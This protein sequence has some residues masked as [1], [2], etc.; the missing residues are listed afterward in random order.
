MS[1]NS[2]K[3]WEKTEDIPRRFDEL[4]PEP[5]WVPVADV[6]RTSREEEA[7]QEAEREKFK[8]KP[9]ADFYF[10]PSEGNAKQGSR[11]RE[12]RTPAHKEKER[13][14]HVPS[15]RADDTSVPPSVDDVT[16]AMVEWA[17]SPDHYLKRKSK[18]AHHDQIKPP[19]GKASPSPL[20][21]D[22]TH[23]AKE[24]PIEKL[25]TVAPRDNSKLASPHRDETQPDMPRSSRGHKP[26][27]PLGAVRRSPQ[28]PVSSRKEQRLPYDEPSPDYDG[29]YKTY[30]SQYNEQYYHERHPN[31]DLHY[32]DGYSYED[33][34]EVDPYLYNSTQDKYQ[35]HQLYPPQQG[36]GNPYTHPYSNP[37]YE[38]REP[39]YMYEA[40]RSP[41]QQ[42]SSYYRS[43]T[44][45]DPR[46][47]PQPHSRYDVLY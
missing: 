46:G 3:P 26:H 34:G 7:R 32:H 27:N 17:L 43:G 19:A 6:I 13:R 23:T 33:R 25:S 9:P 15:K 10:E 12:E 47:Y 2:T 29:D 37:G 16:Q 24:R 5:G 36:Y 45:E 22:K 41:Y 40:Q 20:L 18:P 39:E 21:Q 30:Y 1:D 31:E 38:Y 11:S 8:I 42:P 35:E 4:P 14:S 44:Q 28:Q